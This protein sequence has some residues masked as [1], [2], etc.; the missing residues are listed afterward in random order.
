MMSRREKS[1]TFIAQYW[2]V[3]GTV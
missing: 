2:L 3:A 1:F